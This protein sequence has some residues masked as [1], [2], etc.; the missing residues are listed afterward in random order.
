[1]SYWLYCHTAA[2]VGRDEWNPRV[3]ATTFR[4]SA[5]DLFAPE[6]VP[7][8]TFDIAAL[9]L[10]D[11]SAF[12]GFLDRTV[13][14][15][16]FANQKQRRS[17]EI[18]EEKILPA[19]T[20]YCGIAGAAHR[21]RSSSVGA[22]VKAFVRQ[23]DQQNLAELKKLF[24]EKSV[25]VGNFDLEPN[26]ATKGCFDDDRELNGFLLKARDK[27]KKT[28][29]APEFMFD[30]ARLKANLIID[31]HANTL[32]YVPSFLTKKECVKP[33]QVEDEIPLHCF[34]TWSPRLREHFRICVRDRMEEHFGHKKNVYAKPANEPDGRML[35]N[36]GQ[37]VLWDTH[38]IIEG[39][40]D[41]NVSNVETQQLK[42]FNDVFLRLID[43]SSGP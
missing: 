26:G 19:A 39:Q 37:A 5:N 13:K 38:D 1:M 42:Q 16:L 11:P 24:H 21:W 29:Q 32:G 2:F 20:M 34:E 8:H 30:T 27:V 43:M 28:G 40:M 25:T 18:A 7:E 35:V 31:T 9:N 6:I 33:E 12:A 4:I 41:A 10:K 3:V 36:A 14:A 17:L 15:T 23:S 22:G